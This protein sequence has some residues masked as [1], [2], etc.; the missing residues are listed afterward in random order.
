[1]GL[2]VILAYRALKARQ[3]L[4][5]CRERLAQQVLIQ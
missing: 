3:A 5:G 2:R 4:R 1:M